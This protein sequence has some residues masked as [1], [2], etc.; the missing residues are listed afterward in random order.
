MRR[1]GSSTGE[2]DAPSR[3]GQRA[4][5]LRPRSEAS[6]VPTATEPTQ[7]APETS[8][9]P[10]QL[11]PVQARLRTTPKQIDLSA[12]RELANFSARRAIQQH[13]RRTLVHAM[14]SKLT[15]MVVALAAS[16]GLLWIWKEFG[17]CRLTLYSS[18]AAIGVA[19]F[20]GLEYALLTGRLIVTNRGHVN[21]DWKGSSHH[22]GDVASAES[23]TAEGT[24]NSLDPS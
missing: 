24:G 11:E 9:S 2:A 22:G 23:P 5:P 10:E 14:Y 17:A 19:I 13:S 1:V 21:I 18:L 4:E 15:V 3:A 6:A 16:V 12:F 8:P 7:P 20:W